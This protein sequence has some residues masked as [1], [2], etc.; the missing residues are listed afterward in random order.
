MSRSYEQIR[1]LQ[2]VQGGLFSSLGP[3]IDKFRVDGLPDVED[4][5]VE[6]A[7][8]IT[9]C[10]SIASYNWMGDDNTTIIVPGM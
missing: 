10:N 9:E 1:E 4:I 6:G 5:S 3:L 8:A 2:D 7:L